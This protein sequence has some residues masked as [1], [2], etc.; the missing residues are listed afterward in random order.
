MGTQSQ[1]L[2]NYEATIYN[3]SINIASINYTPAINE[4]EENEDDYHYDNNELLFG[5]EEMKVSLENINKEKLKLEEYLGSKV[6]MKFAMEISV[7]VL[8]TLFSILG[9][10]GK[11]FIKSFI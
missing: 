3:S 6:N 10:L 5:Y 11:K 8:S 4:N 7:L 2:A 1:K 9:I